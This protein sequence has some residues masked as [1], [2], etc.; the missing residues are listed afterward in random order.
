MSHV[1]SLYK[2]KEK[3]KFDGQVDSFVISI[4][5]IDVYYNMCTTGRLI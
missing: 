2:E 4:L 3:E 5:D 1:F